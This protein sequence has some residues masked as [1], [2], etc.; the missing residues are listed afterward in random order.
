MFIKHARD[1]IRAYEVSRK[2]YQWR[3]DADFPAARRWP[4]VN[5]MFGSNRPT[6]N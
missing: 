4:K 1:S 5:W 2:N 3:A 6:M